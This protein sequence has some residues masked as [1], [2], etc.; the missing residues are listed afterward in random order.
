[1]S[2]LK[3]SVN[4]IGKKA[5]TISSNVTNFLNTTSASTLIY[6][7]KNK[8]RV[9]N[10]S[11]TATATTAYTFKYYIGATGQSIDHFIITNAY[12]IGLLNTDVILAG[13]NDDAT[14]TTIAS[15]TLTTG[16]SFDG[17]YSTDYLSE[18]SATATYKYFRITLTP[19]NS[20]TM[21]LSNF[22]MGT[23]F[24]SDNDPEELT[25]EPDKTFAEFVSDSGNVQPFTSQHKPNS[26]E[27]FYRG[28]T[29][30]QINSFISTYEDARK[31]GCYIKNT[32]PTLLNTNDLLNVNVT[33]FK[34]AKL[35]SDFYT[36]N[37]S[38]EE[39]L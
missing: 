17:K 38:F 31:Y 4:N 23:Y 25:I 12:N 8:N 22:Y 29:Q 16:S 5:L 13:S 15:F 32:N 24:V 7:L 28:L 18:F 10:L 30:S 35:W 6:N 26:Y 27:F 3:Y 19:T 36:L 20:G 33:N 34:Y 11:F 39:S 2:F 9:V 37:I 14:Y 21:L 1:M